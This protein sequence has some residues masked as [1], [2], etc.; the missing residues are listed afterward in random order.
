MLDGTSVDGMLMGES[1]GPSAARKRTMLA[2]PPMAIL[3]SF[4]PRECGVA[5]FARDL[6]GAIEHASHLRSLTRFTSPSPW[7]IAMNEAGQTYDYGSQVRL[8]IERDTR[9]DYRLAA[10]RVNASR[11]QVVSIQHE[12]GLFGG[13]YGDYLLDFLSAVDRPVV[14]T[15][16]TVLERPDPALRLVTEQLINKSAATVV[17]AQTAQEILAKYYPRAALNK[18]SFIPHGTPSVRREPTRRFKHELGLDGHT[19]LSTFGLLGPDKGIEYAIR[20]LPEIVARHPDVVYLVLGQTHPGQRKYA[21]ESYREMLKGLVDELDLRDHVRFYNRYLSTP[22]L[23]RFLQATDVYVIPYLNPKQ[24]ASGTLAYAIASGKAVVATPFVYA[25]EMLAGERGMLA[26]FRDPASITGA[27]NG[28]LGNPALKAR[29][30]LKAYNHG[31]RMHWPAVGVA[32]C[33]LLRRVVDEHHAAIRARRAAMRRRRAI[34]A[35]R[36]ATIG[37]LGVGLNLPATRA[38][39]ANGLVSNSGSPRRTSRGQTLSAGLNP[40][41]GGSASGDPMLGGSLVGNSVS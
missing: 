4:P 34:Q 14:L 36:P 2:R 23:L 7:V 39:M 19:V 16:H 8:T 21:G 35:G 11:I 29:V 3:S 6:M 25:R 24:I 10:E 33:R 38:A 37:P 40:L 18:V 27:V 17:L 15:M 41:A 22:E 31:R 30:E 32:Y 13:E 26:K 12:Y 20:A 1:W 9:S 28:L 5:T